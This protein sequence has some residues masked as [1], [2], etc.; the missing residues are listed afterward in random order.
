MCA[1]ADGVLGGVGAQLSSP[2]ARTRG[3]SLPLAVSQAAPASP[4]L[5]ASSS[6]SAAASARCCRSASEPGPPLRAHACV[7]AC[8]AGDITW[9]ENNW[10]NDESRFLAF[11]LHHKEAGGAKARVLLD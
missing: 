3:A 11:T 5:G 2:P 7:R 10:Q 1:C 6:A 9:H 8:R 4:P